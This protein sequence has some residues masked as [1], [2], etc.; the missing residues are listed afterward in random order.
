MQL[1]YKPP[2]KYK[3]THYQY[4]H[5][6]SGPNGAIEFTY[7]NLDN[8]EP[9]VSESKKDREAHYLKLD[10]SKFDGLEQFTIQIDFELDFEIDYSKSESES[11]SQSG[12]DK[13]CHHMKQ[14]YL[15]SL[16]YDPDDDLDDDSNNYN[17]I[18]D[19]IL[20]V[21]LKDQDI[22]DDSQC[23]SY[24]DWGLS[25]VLEGSDRDHYIFE[26][27]PWIRQKER[28]ILTIAADLENQEIKLYEKDA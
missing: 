12:R 21:Y 23:K 4:R 22:T 14:A 15:L 7:S 10:K 24:K 26:K 9:S 19:N 8:I 6:K 17:S 1:I 2:L 5:F 20:S 25:I 27:K 3:K 11:E 28:G 13:N 18:R 16:G